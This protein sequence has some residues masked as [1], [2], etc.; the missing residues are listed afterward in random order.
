[1]SIR[2]TNPEG[3]GGGGSGITALTGDVTASGTGSVAATVVEVGG[4]AAADVAASVADTQNATSSPVAS[5]IAKF[6]GSGDLHA[7]TF[8]GALTGDVTGNVSG[9][10]GAINGVVVSGTAASGK[11]LTATGSGTAD[12]ETPGGSGPYYFLLQQILSDGTDNGTLTS[13]SWFTYPINTISYD[14]SSIASLSSNEFTLPAGTYRLEG[15]VVLYDCSRAKARL[16]DVTNSAVILPGESQYLGGGGSA[17]MLVHGIFTLSGTTVLRME[18]RGESSVSNQG[19]G[20]A[21]SFGDN[22]VY[23]NLNFFKIL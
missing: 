6:D 21:S 1:M 2:I 17:S 23:A 16:Y 18:A 4:A 22:E 9:S 5:A 11:V 10:A 14:P 19:L 3:S 8:F 13:G 7:F 12:W 20:V 15:D